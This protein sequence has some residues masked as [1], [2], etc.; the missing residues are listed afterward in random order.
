MVRRSEGLSSR[1]KK[2]LKFLKKFQEENG[3]S[4][5]SPRRPFWRAVCTACVVKSGRA[6]A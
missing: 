1:H 2:I 4:P 5:I 3:Y 6:S